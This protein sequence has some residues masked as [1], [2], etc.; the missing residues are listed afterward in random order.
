MSP[1]GAPSAS[2]RARR[3]LPRLVRIV[4]AR[5]RLFLAILLGL[6]IVPLTPADWRLATRALAGWDIAVGVYLGFAVRLVPGQAP[7]PGSV[8]DFG[9][10]GLAG[11]VFWVD[12][13]E[14]LVVVYMVQACVSK[15]PHAARS[16][17][18]GAARSHNA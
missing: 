11:T 10:S 15:T 9:W 16:R 13:A 1:D 6:V 3:R 14:Q 5:P 18:P 7:W 12:Q 4:R 2:Q 8:G 17:P